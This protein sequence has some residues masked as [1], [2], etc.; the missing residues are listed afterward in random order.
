[1]PATGALSV[2]LVMI[3]I[4]VSLVMSIVIAEVAVSIAIPA[5]IVFNTAAV[6]LPVAGVIS[7]AIVARRN[8]TRSLVRWPGPV[9]FVPFVVPADRIPVTRHPDVLR[10]WAWGNHGNHPRWRRCPSH[11][12]DRNLGFTCAS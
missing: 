12:S 3:M 10:S 5:V 8:P 7:F 1:M 11:D 9:S 6:S 4:T 2:I